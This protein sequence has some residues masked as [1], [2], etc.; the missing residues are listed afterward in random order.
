LAKAENSFWK[1][2]S[3]KRISM[4][5][6]EKNVAVIFAGGSGRRMHA[7]ARPKQFL[8]LHG[9]P[10]IV[11]T[12][13]LFEKHPEID[14]I[15]VACIE[16]W[17]GY[18]NGLIRQYGLQKVRGVVAGGET[19]QDSIYNGL[20][21]AA[22]DCEKSDSTVVLIHDG[23]RPLIQ[24]QTISD[25]IMMARRKGSCITCVEATETFVVKGADGALNIPS[26]KDSLI[27]RAPQTFMLADILKAHEEARAEGRHDYIDSLTLMTHYGAHIETVLGP[28]E[29]IKI[30]TPTDYFI[31][32]AIVEARENSQIFGI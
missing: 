30:T 20:L 4:K 22:G 28:T 23:V 8:E 3:E 21:A 17:L 25:N 16:N 12:L 24:P 13:E 5:R 1:N 19:G 29:N 10:I 11:Y 9:K 27:A 7:G 31:F 6:E 15:Y 26:R 2:N 14:A 18:M 32:K